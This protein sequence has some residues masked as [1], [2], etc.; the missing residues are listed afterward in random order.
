MPDELDQV[1]DEAIKSYSEVEPSPDLAR[2]I[3]YQSQVQNASPRHGWKL[4]PAFAM[5]AAAA[6][7]L[8]LALLGQWAMPKP[9]A[10]IAS[11][12][13]VPSVV[14]THSQPAK[15]LAVTA[16]P[17]QAHRRDRKAASRRKSWARPLPPPYSKEELALLNFVQQHPK[18]AAEIAESQKRDSQP[19]TISQLKI[20]PL[21]IAPLN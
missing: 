7:A 18:E 17:V 4:A 12:P 19:I 20:E 14:E 13:S 15:A 2:R 10:N 8:A 1:L 21:S 11:A 3:L 6:A 9:P 5:P 16:E